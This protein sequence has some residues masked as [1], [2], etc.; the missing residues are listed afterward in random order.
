MHIL[1]FLASPEQVNL[2]VVK[3]D[4]VVSK[5]SAAALSRYLARLSYPS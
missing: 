4:S 5:P 3:F 1:C 2:V